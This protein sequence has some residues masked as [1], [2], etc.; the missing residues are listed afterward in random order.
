MSALTKRVRAQ[1]EPLESEQDAKQKRAKVD[2]QA[3]RTTAFYKWPKFDFYEEQ[4]YRLKRVAIL[5]CSDARLT[6]SVAVTATKDWANLHKHKEMFQ[7]FVVTFT[8]KTLTIGVAPNTTIEE[9]K[10]LIFAKTDIL[11]SLQRLIFAGKQL[12][13]G[14]TCTDYK[15]MKESTVHLVPQLRGC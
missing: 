14:R 8:G 6:T 13:D 10:L 1:S 9:I 4:L 7:I 3:V 11:P 5:A 2:V 12:E 15:M